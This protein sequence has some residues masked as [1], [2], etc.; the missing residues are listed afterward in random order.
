MQGRAALPPTRIVI[1]RC[2]LVEAELF[3]V[4]GAN[5]LRRIDGAFL[6]RGIDISAGDLL[7]HYAELLQR[8]ARP[9]A[10]AEFEPLEIVNGLDLFAEPAPH[11]CAGVAADQ[12]INI[13][14]LGK[15][16]HQNKAVAV[17]EPGVLQAPVETKRD[18]TEQ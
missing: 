15:F 18:G 17:V 1:K 6:E 9:A 3:V 5:P 7:R 8:L 12:A 4:V 2:D 14:L 10:D 13:R 16:I 11:L